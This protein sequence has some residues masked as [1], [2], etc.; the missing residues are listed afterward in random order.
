MSELNVELIN[1]EKVEDS[2]I[3]ENHEKELLFYNKLENEAKKL[4]P[5]R[6]K[7]EVIN[8]SQDEKVENQENNN[9]EQQP[10]NETKKLKQKRIRYANDDERTAAILKSKRNYY[11]RNNDLYKLKSRKRYYITRLSKQDL[12]EEK[13]IKYADKL[14]EIDEQIK[15]LDIF[16]RT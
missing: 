10:E 11:H 9:L 6:I 5:K 7:V 12:P 8:D 13:R 4:K 2:Q 15:A 1:D 16:S 3:I 14:N